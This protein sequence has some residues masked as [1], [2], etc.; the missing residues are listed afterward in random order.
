MHTDTLTTCNAYH[1]SLNSALHKVFKDNPEGSNDHLPMSNSWKQTRL[2]PACGQVRMR[3]TSRGAR[4]RSAYMRT[5]M[6]D[7]KHLYLTKV[8]P[9]NSQTHV[10]NFYDMKSQARQ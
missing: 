1:L 10:L 3:F 6:R 8:N 7:R 2:S 9:L 4:Y 5:C